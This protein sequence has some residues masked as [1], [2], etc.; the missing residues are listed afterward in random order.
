MKLT[1]YLSQ[2]L[3]MAGVAA[4]TAIPAIRLPRMY[5]DSITDAKWRKEHFFPTI[6]YFVMC[7]VAMASTTA[8]LVCG[9]LVVQFQ[10]FTRT[11]LHADVVAAGVWA[12]AVVIAIV[13]ILAHPP[14]S[15]HLTKFYLGNKSWDPPLGLLER[16]V[17]L[18]GLELVVTA[19]LTFGAVALAGAVA[20]KHHSVGAAFWV[21]ILWTGLSLIVIPAVMVVLLVLAWIITGGR[22]RKVPD[23]T[24]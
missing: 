10:E 9:P 14:F 17:A 23:T 7:G 24:Q 2:L 15:G 3:V 1:E 22:P 8:L 12:V 20:I 4:A 6:G 21:L 16:P 13:V 19:T 18:D 5:P 11:A